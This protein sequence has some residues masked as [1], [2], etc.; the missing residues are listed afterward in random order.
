MLSVGKG[1]FL[2]CFVCTCV[3]VCMCVCVYVCMYVCMYVCVCVCMYVCTSPYE[4]TDGDT[5]DKDVSVWNHWKKTVSRSDVWDKYGPRKPVQ[6]SPG[7]HPASY[8]VSTGSFQGGKATGAW[9]WP[10]TPS[11]AEVKERVELYLYSPS[12][13]SWPVI[14]WAL[15]LPLSYKKADRSE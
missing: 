5:A 15:P 4:N 11:S 14:G 1:G 7:A 3:C 10:P 13:S 6:T 12:G 9:R 8:T 2:T